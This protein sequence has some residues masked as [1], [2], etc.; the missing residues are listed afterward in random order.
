MTAPSP[1]PT[2][3]AAGRLRP[4]RVRRS[5]GGTGCIGTGSSGEPPSA[6]W[7]VD[8][9]SRV[10]RA[11]G[12]PSDLEELGL[13]VLEQLV[14][15]THV[16]LGDLLELLLRAVRVVLADL[17]VLGQPVQ[18]V[19]RVPANVADRDPGVLRL[20][21]R[22]LDE[23]LAAFLGELR[24]DDPDDGAVVRRVHP[25]VGVADGLLDGAHRALVE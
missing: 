24:E 19:L 25:E 8:I 15:V 6:S 7:S 9:V 5:G 17:A 2:A 11:D 16:F 4:A 23:L 21:V 22:H 14:D 1:S 18:L 3:I 12:R 10:S 20:L 13:L